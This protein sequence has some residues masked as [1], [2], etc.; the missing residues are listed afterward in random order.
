MA[1]QGGNRVVL[2]QQLASRH[3]RR[4]RVIGA[5]WRIFLTPD[6]TVLRHRAAKTEQALLADTAPVAPANIG[7]GAVPAF[8]KITRPGSPP[9][10]Y[11]A[12]PDC[13]SLPATTAKPP[14]AAAGSGEC[15]PGEA[16]R[17]S[18]AVD[19]ARHALLLKRE[20]GTLK[21]FAVIQRLTEKTI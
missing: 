18:D 6:Q 3:G 20:Q 13:I 21:M 2:L 19:D 15:V 17:V 5:G 1:E 9:G 14:Q 4:L 10:G 16:V 12:S 7:D 11:R 8:D